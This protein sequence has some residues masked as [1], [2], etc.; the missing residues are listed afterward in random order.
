MMETLKILIEMTTAII[1]LASTIIA[2][3]SIRK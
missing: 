2:V 3:K 1:N